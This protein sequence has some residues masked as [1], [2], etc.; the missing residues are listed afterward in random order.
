MLGYAL[1]IIM[2][3]V[4]MLNVVMINVVAHQNMNDI[5]AMR[6]KARLAIKAIVVTLRGWY[7]G[8]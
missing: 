5:A 1:L 7:L 6:P 8:N 3:S 2:L 4:I